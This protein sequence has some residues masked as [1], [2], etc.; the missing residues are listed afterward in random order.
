MK[1]GFI[2]LSVASRISW[3]GEDYVVEDQSSLDH[4]TARRVS[5]SVRYS[6]PVHEIQSAIKSQ[7]ATPATTAA[8]L[9]P[10]SPGSNV[11][12]PGWRA[13][14]RNRKVRVAAVTAPGEV[15]PSAAAVKLINDFNR[16]A[17]VSALPKGSPERSAATIALA[18]ALGCSVPT[19]YRKLAILEES[20]SA[21][22]LARAQRSDKGKVRV[23]QEQLQVVKENLDTHYFC[24]EPKSLEDI[25]V[26]VNGALRGK[27]L[28][29]VSLGTMYKIAKSLKT[30]KEKLAA[31]GRTEVIRDHFDSRAGKLPDA[32]FPLAVVEIDH[33][34]IQIIFVDEQERMP[35]RKGY[36][37]LAIDC[38]SRM[39]LGFYISLDPPS[40]ISAGMAL[41]HAFL[42]KDDYLRR[43]GC[44]GK[45]PCWGSPVVIICDNAAEL[46]GY[47]MQGA[48]SR[49]RFDIRD[50]PVNSPK[51]GGHIESVFHTFVREQKTIPGT[52]KSN[53]ID[54]GDY[55]SEGR[56][57]MTIAEYE[58]KF[59]EYVVNDYHLREHS[60]PEMKRRCP[61]Q[62]WEAGTMYGD[63]FPPTGLPELPT[64]S[65]HLRISLM[66]L[67]W[68]IIK[69][70]KLELNTHTY[71]SK[72]LA[73]LGDMIDPSD[74]KSNRL[75]EVR[76]DPRNI[77]VIW[78]RN[79]DTDEYIEAYLQNHALRG[80][81]EWE[82]EELRKRQGRPALVFQEE[83]HQSKLRQDEMVAASAAKTRKARSERTKKEQLQRQRKEAISPRSKKPDQ[84]LKNNPALRKLKGFG[85]TR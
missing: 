27:K 30:P 73:R 13:K 45:W 42:P 23:G 26:R 64:D 62:R 57:T 3:R 61:Y 12:N 36:L 84:D 17:Q 14:L 47:V 51:F 67:E 7:E 66:P 11:E 1:P 6:I 19:A 29:E 63:I 24:R 9:A 8:D 21:M 50:R 68:R 85:G 22:G 60:A 37:T 44:K 53:P 72:E 59:A 25:Q 43:V 34:P 70:A 35:M 79:P 31:Q 78:V 4:I 65:I 52:T 54:R 69:G 18:R 71:F 15:T 82:D 58:A 32:D 75:F 10:S 56:A 81:S 5:D 55:D 76:H 49:Y 83:R 80:V 74:P 38:F 16:I 39:V 77:D 28:K 48:S 2:D 46:N 33:T 20:H 41:A 40:S